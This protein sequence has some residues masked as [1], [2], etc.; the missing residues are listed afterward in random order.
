MNSCGAEEQVSS[1]QARMSPPAHVLAAVQLS[2]EVELL[3]VLGKDLRGNQMQSVP[4]AG[5]T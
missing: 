2:E 1:E 4:A 3:D 5:G